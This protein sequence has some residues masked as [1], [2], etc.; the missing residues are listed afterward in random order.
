MRALT[1]SKAR[2]HE[3]GENR[4]LLVEDRELEQARSESPPRGA[5]HLAEPPG[6]A[7]APPPV[8]ATKPDEGDDGEQGREDEAEEN[9]HEEAHLS[10]ARR[11]PAP[12]KSSASFR[13]DRSMCGISRS[14]I[15]LCPT[16]P[17]ARRRSR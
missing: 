3:V 1:R 13:R 15:T 16:R 9:E 8:R 10:R 11:T 5:L 14:R 6:S 7:P 2:G 4:F 17:S 12:S